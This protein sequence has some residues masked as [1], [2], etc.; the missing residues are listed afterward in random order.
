MF[1]E[2]TKTE[3]KSNKIFKNL[4]YFKSVKNAFLRRASWSLKIVL[5]KVGPAPVIFL[6]SWG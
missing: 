4:D 3:T 2:A 1:N 5:S 6:Q